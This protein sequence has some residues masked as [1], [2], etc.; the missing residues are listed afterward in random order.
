MLHID[1]NRPGLMTS[2]SVCTPV[3]GDLIQQ[4]TSK[5]IWPFEVTA[6][7]KISGVQN[8]LSDTQG[9]GLNY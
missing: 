2:I 4:C 6:Q 3:V 1:N 5:G 9:E 8:G 7:V